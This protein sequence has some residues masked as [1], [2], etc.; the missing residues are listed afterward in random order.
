M[1]TNC[2]PTNPLC[3]SFLIFFCFTKLSVIFFASWPTSYLELR[4][5]VNHKF[6]AKRHLIKRWLMVWELAPHKEYPILPL[7]PFHVKF[8][9]QHQPCK[10]LD[11]FQYS[12]F[13][14]NLV[15]WSQNVSSVDEFIQNECIWKHYFRFSFCTAPPIGKQEEKDLTIYL[16][17]TWWRCN[18]EGLGLQNLT[19]VP[20]YSDI[21]DISIGQRLISF[22]GDDIH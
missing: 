8:I 11:F 2:Y 12:C 9:F 20:P 4:F 5:E 13:P 1:P 15:E 7:Q 21:D 17:K 16:S 22:K 14:N 18:L 19:R 6:F 3:Y 10:H